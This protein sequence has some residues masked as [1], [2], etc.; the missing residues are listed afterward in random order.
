MNGSSSTDSSQSAPPSRGARARR[1]AASLSAGLLAV[2]AL[3]G[4]STAA[5]QPGPTTVV[6]GGLALAAPAA[7]PTGLSTGVGVGVSRGCTFAWGVRAS[8]STATE[9]TLAWEVRDDDVRL[10]AVGEL[11]RAVGRGTLALRLGVGGTLVHELRTR[12]QGARAG[13]TGND[14]ETSAWSLLPAAD[15]EAVVLL[16]FSPSW[17]AILSGGPSLHLVD[18]ALRA[19]WTSFVGVGWQP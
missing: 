15:L 14:L 3:L 10:R 8:W 2:A 11:Q 9:Y 1:G 6:D 5:A 12:T 19:G 7:L 16:H 17:S 13:L 4:A 18:G